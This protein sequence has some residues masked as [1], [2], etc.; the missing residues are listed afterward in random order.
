MR[1]AV[2]GLFFKAHIEQCLQCNLWLF[3]V[4]KVGDYVAKP[5]TLVLRIYFLVNQLSQFIILFIV[6]LLN[7]FDLLSLSILPNLFLELP[8]IVIHL[9]PNIP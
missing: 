2:G 3:L 1:H 5:H 8:V 7:H 4:P 9:H 6:L